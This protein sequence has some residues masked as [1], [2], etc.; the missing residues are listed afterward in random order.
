M[1]VQ[2]MVVIELSLP[3]IAPLR[4]IEAEACG[5]ERHILGVPLQRL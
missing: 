5:H 4:V 3:P 2:P 1:G